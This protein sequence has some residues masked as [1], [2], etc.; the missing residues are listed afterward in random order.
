[1][2]YDK[3]KL[4]NIAMH[5]FEDA[6]KQHNKATEL[7]DRGTIQFRGTKTILKVLLNRLNNRLQINTCIALNKNKYGK[8][9]VAEE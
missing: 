8:I 7:G 6:A 9:S 1:M 3:N 4:H 5:V 2:I